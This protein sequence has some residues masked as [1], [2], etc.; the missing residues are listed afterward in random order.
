[1]QYFGI[2]LKFEDKIVHNLQF[3]Q[4]KYLKG[5]KKIPLSSNS[6]QNDIYFDFDFDFV[7]MIHNY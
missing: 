6:E 4:I 3:D 7:Q 5:D 2:P 1:V